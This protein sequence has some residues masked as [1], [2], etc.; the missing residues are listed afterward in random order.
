MQTPTKA[1]RQL[2][3]TPLYQYPQM[4][5][6]DLGVHPAL[7]DPRVLKVSKELVVSPENLV[8]RDHLGQWVPEVYL[9]PPVRTAC[10]VR[11]ENLDPRV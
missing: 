11:M 10:L 5:S 2:L 1:L 7:W 9:V 4:V 3:S 6:Q 8:S